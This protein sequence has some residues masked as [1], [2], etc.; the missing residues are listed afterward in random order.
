M[1]KRYCL[2]GHPGLI[3]RRKVRQTGTFISLLHAEQSGHDPALS[4]WVIVCE[5]H[6]WVQ[7]VDTLAL[8]RRHMSDP[9]GWC[10]YCSGVSKREEDQEPDEAPAE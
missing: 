8:G 5:Q 3:E 1:A 10:E 4:P 2:N 6:A 9:K 7:N